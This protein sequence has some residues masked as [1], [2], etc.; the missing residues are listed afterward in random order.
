VNDDDLGVT[1]GHELLHHAQFTNFSRFHQ[2]YNALLKQA[3]G[4]YLYIDEPCRESARAARQL[5]GLMALVEGDALL[6]QQTLERDYFPKHSTPG[7]VDVAQ[8][9]LLLALSPS[10]REAVARK[11]QQYV[12]GARVLTDCCGVDASRRETV[13]PLYRDP[14]RAI[15]LFDP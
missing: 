7:V 5:E 8:M 13:N 4:H 2:R 9:S 14:D 1:V 6:F 3:I 11:A 12:H 15:R 10:L